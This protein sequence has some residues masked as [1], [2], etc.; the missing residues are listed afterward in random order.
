MTAFRTIAFVTIA[1]LG[2]H[3]FGQ[4]DAGDWSR[5]AAVEQ[6]HA[7]VNMD[8]GPKR[9]DPAARA[10]IEARNQG[11]ADWAARVRDTNLE[12]G[13]DTCLLAIA[14]YMGGERPQAADALFTHIVEHG[15][16]PQ[17]M[18]PLRGFIPRMLPPRLNAAIASGDWQRFNLVLPVAVAWSDDPY[19]LLASLGAVVRS[20]P[21]PEAR[22]SLLELVIVLLSDDRIESLE[23]EAFLERVYGQ[24]RP[25]ADG[26]RNAPD[27]LARG[28]GAS[29]P[30]LVTAEEAAKTQP[31]VP[32]KPFAGPDLDGEE[33]STLD[34][35]RG[36]VVLIDFW[37]TWCGP[38]IREMPSIVELKKK[39]GE[40]GLVILGVSLDRPNAKQKILDNMKRLGM[41]W[42]Q[43][44][45]GQGWKTAPAR[46]NNI[47]SIPATIILDRTGKARYMN[48]R[49]NRLEAAIRE[50]LG[51]PE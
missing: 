40:Q 21:G 20:T 24:S 39:Y 10:R 18:Q 28:V 32:F 48:L 14:D 15:G 1:L 6:L 13:E 44:Y 2:Q 34:F 31:S 29:R 7:L 50:L 3:A 17:S 49:G 26:G 51:L 35:G 9:N 25:R 22:E 37:A 36:K 11:I 23:R 27:G 16:L 30:Q 41:D 4:D 38:C 12:L 47:R 45:D 5:S 46:L 43:I 19:P 33:I 8:L 42:P